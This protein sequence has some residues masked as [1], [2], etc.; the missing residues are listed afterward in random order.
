MLTELNVILPEII[1]WCFIVYGVILAIFIGGIVVLKS[2]KTCFQLRKHKYQGIFT[3]IEKSWKEAEALRV[4]GL[5]L[6]DEK[7]LDRWAKKVDK[8]RMGIYVKIKE[9]NPIL[10][11]KFDIPYRFTMELPTDSVGLNR[12]NEMVLRM[13][14]KRMEILKEIQDNYS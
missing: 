8:W 3:E 5:R 4:E 13:L 14:M 10:A 11:E 6:E 12:R 7:A 1:G 2:D 9:F